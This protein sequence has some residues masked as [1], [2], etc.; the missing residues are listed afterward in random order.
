MQLR[1]LIGIMALTAAFTACRQDAGETSA[2]AGGTPAA[3]PAQ[4]VEGRSPGK[5]AAPVDIEY[6]ILGTPLVGQ[7]VAVEIRLSSPAAGQRLRIQYS[8]NDA[9]S[10]VFAD[11]QPRSIDVEIPR[12]ASAAARQV[13][14]VPQREGRV[15]LNVAAEVT[16]ENGMMLKSIAI[17]ISVGSNAVTLETNGALKQSDGETVLSLPAR[18]D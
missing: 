15:Y 13:R 14:V 5:P 8:I 9:G 4:A 17:P 2:G 10:L 16:T 12:D 11:A 18:E 7:P 3:A 6:R 1:H